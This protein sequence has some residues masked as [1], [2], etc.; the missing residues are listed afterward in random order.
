[1]RSTRPIV[2]SA[3]A[4]RHRQ[5]RHKGRSTLS[6]PG[7]IQLAT[8][9]GGSAT[10]LRVSSVSAP[11]S[12]SRWLA[13]LSIS[14]STSTLSPPIRSITEPL[15]RAASTI[16]RSLRSLGTWCG[17]SACSKALGP[18][19]VA[20]VLEP[21]SRPWPPRPLLTSGRPC[22]LQA[23]RNPSALR[24]FARICLRMSR[25]HSGRCFSAHPTCQVLKV[26]RPSS[27]S[28]AM[29]T[30]CSSARPASLRRQTLQTRTIRLSNC[31]TTDRART[32][33]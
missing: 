10:E 18:P 21:T 20:K 13:A 6:V 22:K 31:F 16:Q 26:V 32:A 33:T 24:A 25:R 23:L 5:S 8:S 27:A 3:S 7:R 17:V 9:S 4:L 19:S 2:V 12:M 15:V 29:G 28:T 30:I 14:R 1:M 11:C